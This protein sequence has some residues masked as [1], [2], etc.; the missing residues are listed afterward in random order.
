MEDQEEFLKLQHCGA[1]EGADQEE[2]GP[3]GETGAAVLWSNKRM[4]EQEEFLELQHCGAIEGADK[5]HGDLT[6]E[7]GRCLTKRN[8]HFSS[9]ILLLRKGEGQFLTYESSLF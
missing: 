5:E 4:E 3:G 8:E 6:K 1:I 2:E 7:Y 9:L